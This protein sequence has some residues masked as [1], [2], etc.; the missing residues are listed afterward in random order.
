MTAQNSIE[1]LLLIMAQ[2]RDKESGCP[3]DRKQT[4]DSIIPHTIEETYEVVDAIHK[5]D[6]ENLKEELGDLLFQVIFYA[7]M[8]KEEGLFDFNDV[9]ETLNE[10]LVRR[11]P[12]VFGSD[13]FSSEEEIAAN[14]DKVKQK[15]RLDKGLLKQYSSSQQS[16]LDSIPSALPGLL[17]ANKIQ[18]QCAKVGFDWDE[19]KPVAD[20]VNEEVAEVLE[21]ALKIPR[22]EDKLEEELGDL[23]FATVNFS[24]H[25]GKNPEQALCKANDKFERR[26]RQI[27]VNV[28]KKH[29]TIQ[30]CDLN[31]LD[32]EW[33]NVKRSEQ[34]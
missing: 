34:N 32:S 16:I 20:K 10:K 8:T 11:H 26:F 21:E 2:L 12:H 29:K 24:R 3:W 14:W 6:W 30:Q 33:E 31:E 25:L 17:R 5:K 13:V 19:L 28:A 4:F 23:L 18:K 27:E 22:D 1:Q 15:E 7:Q 9:V